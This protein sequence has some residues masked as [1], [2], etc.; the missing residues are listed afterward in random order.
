MNAAVDAG[1]AMQSFIVAAESVGLGCCP[2]SEIRDHIDALSTAL[3]L[4]QWVFPVAGL[5]VGRPVEAGRISLRLPLEVTVHTD[6]YDDSAMIEHV[7]DYDRRREAIE[8]TKPDQQ[9]F[10]A[11]FGVSHDY[12]WSENRT[13]QYAVP[14]RTDFGRYIREQGFDLS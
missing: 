13:R 2:V 4:P 1:I 9:R 11:Q 10:V 3:E 6:R 14:A 8:K 7:A 5:C 12:G